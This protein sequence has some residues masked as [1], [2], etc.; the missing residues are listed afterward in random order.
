[1]YMNQLDHNVFDVICS[2]SPPG[3]YDAEIANDLEVTIHPE[4]SESLQRLKAAK[5]IVF[6]RAGGWKRRVF[7]WA[8]V[9]STGLDER[10]GHLLEVGMVATTTSLEVLDSISVVMHYS[11]EF[12]SQWQ[13]EPVVRQM[14]NQSGLFEEARDRTRSSNREDANN[15][16]V[17]FIAKWGRIGLEPM[18][19]SSVS[20]DRR[21]I[22][23]HL[24]EVE[25]AFNYRSIDVSSV[26]ELATAWDESFVDVRSHAPHRSIP[27]IHRSIDLA[28]RFKADYFTR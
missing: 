9:E 14:H 25:K 19:G 24:P 26:L 28:R 17:G 4:V 15:R 27:D 12:Q 23:H 22:R 20:F 21:W 18:C 5:K 3:K 6:D 2:A 10:E 16:L 11:E 8:D 13:M 1:M 7:L